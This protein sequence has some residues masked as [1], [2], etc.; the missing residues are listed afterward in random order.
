[1]SKTIVTAIFAFAAMSVMFAGTANAKAPLPDGKYTF[2]NG[3]ATLYVTLTNKG[4]DEKAVYEV[5][6]NVG[7]LSASSSDDGAKVVADGPCDT[8]WTLHENSNGW[9]FLHSKN[10]ANALSNSDGKGTLKLRRNNAGGKGNADQ[11]WQMKK[12][13]K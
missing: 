3:P 9:N 8:F 4:D 7:Y 6:T 5:D 13:Q 10:G 1:M 11:L 2:T 12:G